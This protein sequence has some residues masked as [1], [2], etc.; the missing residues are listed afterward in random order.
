MEQ[1]TQQPTHNIEGIPY[2]ATGWNWGAFL[3]GPIWGIGNRVWISLL[4]LI[5]FVGFVMA[6]V[7]G[8]KG[9]TWAWKQKPWKDTRHF[10]RA[11][12]NWAIAGAG[13]WAIIIMMIIFSP[14]NVTVNPQD[15]SSITSDHAASEE[16]MGKMGDT[17]RSNEMEYKVTNARITKR[18]NPGY[19]DS[20]SPES[21]QFVVVDI[22]I[23][24][25]GQ[26]QIHVS[27]D[28]IKL[29]DDNGSEYIMSESLSTS[30]NK[31]HFIYEEMNPN[32]TKKAKLVF[33]TCEKDVDSFK[34]YAYPKR[35]SSSDPA[36]IKL[37]K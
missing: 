5:P 1:Q 32:A 4:T 3:L 8:A 12:F 29:V 30:G 22:I 34:I 13:V 20:Q 2:E 19:G 6:F 27:H 25:I 15:Q 37:K 33:D 16:V 10:K 18:A 36:I 7:L 17:V 14:S 23:K 35:F 11:Q 21:G 24:N 9:G 26:E 31:G 28:M